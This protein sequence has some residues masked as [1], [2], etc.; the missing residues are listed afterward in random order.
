MYLNGFVVGIEVVFEK[1]F[2]NGGGFF[3]YFICGNLVD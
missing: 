2:E 1:F 3:D